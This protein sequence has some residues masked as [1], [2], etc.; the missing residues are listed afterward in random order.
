MSDWASDDLPMLILM[1][2]GEGCP[3]LTPSCGRSL[4]ESAAVCLEER[5]HDG[6]VKLV[7]IGDYETAF[8]L[9]RPS[10]TDQMSRCYN[11]PEEAT[12]LGACGVAV[13]LIREL[14]GFTVVERSR[15][16]TGF[17][18]WLGEE[19]DDLFARKA[20]LEVSGIRMGSQAHLISRV[21][22]KHQQTQQSGALRLPAYV[23]VVEF[24]RP[25]AHVTNR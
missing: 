20:R 24:S 6:Q 11:D 13:L 25:A 15:R 2:L 12:E 16:G 7:V 22:Q 8:R 23:V 5:G 1:R 18:Y 10:V 4:A 19:G 17:D 9:V 21:K 3:A 14:V